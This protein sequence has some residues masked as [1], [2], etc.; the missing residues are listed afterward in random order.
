MN[1]IEKINIRKTQ[2]FWLKF[3]KFNGQNFLKHHQNVVFRE[4]VWLSEPSRP[5]FTNS[6]MHFPVS[7][8]PKSFCLAGQFKIFGIF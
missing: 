4:Y 3:E 5:I 2:I 8:P 6:S 1:P 7:G